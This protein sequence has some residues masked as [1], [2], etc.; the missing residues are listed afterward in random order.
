[1]LKIASG[2]TFEDLLKENNPDGKDNSK[3]GILDFFTKEQMPEAISKA[4]FS[5]AKDHVS[6]PVQSEFGWHILKVLEK[7]NLK[8]PSFEEVAPK[9]K[10][11]LYQKFVQEYVDN[12]LRD[13][14]V[15][16]TVK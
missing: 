9:I 4:A 12:L 15:E 8:A 14:K 16:I 10:A 6:E 13:N 5:L 7:R 1:M 2:K 11:E 3:G